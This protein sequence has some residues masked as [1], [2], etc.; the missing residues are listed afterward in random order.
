MLTV[1]LFAKAR[2]LVGSPAIQIPWSDG[3]TVGRLKQ[4]L[5][6]RHPLLT[7][8]VPR[9]LVAVNNDYASD[10]LKVRASDE[11]ACFPPVSGG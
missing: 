3:D 7:P 10:G 5:S 2:E 9:L 8:L 6:E 11:V 4:T 1:K